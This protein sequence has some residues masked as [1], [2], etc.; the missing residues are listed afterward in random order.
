MHE[1]ARLSFSSYDRMFPNQD[2]IPKGGFGN[3]IAL[4]FQKSA[5]QNGGSIFVDDELKPFA[6]Q[7]A[8]LSSIRKICKA[9]LEAWIAHWHIPPLGELRQEEDP[10]EPKPWQPKKGTALTSA[11]FPAEMHCVITSLPTG[12][13]SQSKVFRRGRKTA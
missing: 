10:D 8:F 13:T 9:Q 3:L 4:P 6:D 7:W 11:D 1:N 12:A 5:Y 2:V